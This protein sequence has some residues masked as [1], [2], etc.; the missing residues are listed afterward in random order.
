MKE[1]HRGILRVPILPWG[2]VNAFI[3]Y[4]EE[5]CILVDAGLPDTGPKFAASLKTIGRTLSDVTLI[6]VT[7]GHVD[8]AGAAAWLRES[9]GAPIVAHENETPFLSGEKKMSFCPTRPFGRLLLGS[10]LPIAPYERFSPDIALRGAGQLDLTKHG[11]P[12]RVVSTPGHT[13]GSISV[14][15][16]DGVALVGDLLAS[17]VLLGGIAWTERPE[18]PPFEEEPALVAEQ[19][20]SLVESGCSQFF[21]G[22]GGPVDASAV[23][24]HAERLRR[25]A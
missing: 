22:H 17:G 3:V 15:R 12:G 8:H 24:R 16:N 4:S 13:P 20:E 2:M 9:T 19:L 11:I 7:H 5:A 23:K 21:L 14:V 1:K 6:V 25:I 18:R 10:G